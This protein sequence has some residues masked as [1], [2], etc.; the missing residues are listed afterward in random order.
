MEG[1][2]D[3]KRVSENKIKSYVVRELEELGFRCVNLARGVFDVYI[4]GYGMFLE[5][6]K[7][8]NVKKNGWISF[9]EKQIEAVDKLL[10]KPIIVV[11]GENPIRFYVLT[12]EEVELLVSEH[13]KW[14]NERD[15][16]TRFE[17][18]DEVVG[19][20]C[21]ILTRSLTYNNFRQDVDVK[22]T[23]PIE[24]LHVL[25]IFYLLFED[26]KTLLER[27]EKLREKVVISRQ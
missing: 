19:E 10:M 8:N 14:I 7:I 1:E 3:F 4:D 2:R 12:P 27:L 18:L 23:I 20:I 22:N 26:A 16:K 24:W 5:F 6:K 15:F 21:R 17:S 9:T 11:F 13:G 25:K